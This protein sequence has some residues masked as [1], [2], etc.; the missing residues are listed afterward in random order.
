[1]SSRIAPD[2][3]RADPAA[4]HGAIVRLQRGRG[5]RWVAVLAL[6]CTIGLY[7]AEASHHHKTEAGELHCPV[8][9]VVAHGALDLFVPGIGS[10][11]YYR[12]PYLVAFS[13]ARPF[14]PEQS[15]TIHPP[16]RA[17]PLRSTVFP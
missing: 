16:S 5:F 4:L 3:P 14:F 13:D 1:M 6:L 7:A 10:V 15:I 9:Q 12:I 17:P 8:C 2:V 11:S